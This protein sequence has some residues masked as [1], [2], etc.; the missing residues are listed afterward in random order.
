MLRKS[1]GKKKNIYILLKERRFKR[2]MFFFK[3]VFKKCILFF[4]FNVKVVV[5]YVCELRSN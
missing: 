3:V 4:W 2:I 5:F 1:I